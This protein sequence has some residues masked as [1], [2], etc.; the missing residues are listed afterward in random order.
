[1]KHLFFCLFFALGNGLYAQSVPEPKTYDKEPPSVFEVHLNGRTYEITEGEIVKI[2]TMIRPQ[3]HIRQLPEKKFENTFCTFNYPKNLTFG[4]DKDGPV[5]TWTLDGADMV[6][7]VYD[8]E[9]LGDLNSITSTVVEQFGG[10]PSD[11]TDTTVN[12][13]GRTLNG[14]VVNI[15]L[16]GELLCQEYYRVTFPNGRGGYIMFQDSMNDGVHSAEY[17][18]VLGCFRRS[19]AFKKDIEPL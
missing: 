17:F 16:A 1:M 2:D 9:N 14:K 19:I 13:G 8:L 3:F 7:M 6:V 11:I 10:K 12:F 4:Y 5:T 15:R 18:K